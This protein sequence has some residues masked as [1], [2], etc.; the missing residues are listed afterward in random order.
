M[1]VAASIALV[2]GFLGYIKPVSQIILE[3]EFNMDL[4]GRSL[5]I[6]IATAANFVGM[7]VAG[8]CSDR[9]SSRSRLVATSLLLMSWSTV[10]FCL[11]SSFLGL[12][13]FCVSVALVGLAL[14]FNRAAG[15][16]LLADLVDRHR[17]GSYGMA[18]ALADMADSLGLILGPTLG[19]TISQNYGK[20]AGAVVLGGLC[21]LLLPS[22]LAIP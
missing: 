7:P 5:I 22:L 2:Y 14:A 13:A 19:L 4:I 17:L 18:F 15:S 21:L 12:P 6:T 1:E 11:R 8:W 20:N 3:D 9:V 10:F 16:A